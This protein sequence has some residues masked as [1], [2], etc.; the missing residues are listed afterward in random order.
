MGLSA[1]LPCMILIVSLVQRTRSPRAFN[2]FRKMDEKL[3]HDR[4]QSF[5]LI[6]PLFR[7]FALFCRLFAA[8]PAPTHVSDLFTHSPSRI[9]SFVVP[10][11][12]VKRSNCSAVSVFLFS[13][14]LISTS[15]VDIRLRMWCFY[16]R[17]VRFLRRSSRETS[18][19]D[20]SSS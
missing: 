2:T 18:S 11:G 8:I 4:K 3:H 5:V 14:P 12:D 16:S 17:K 15:I 6:Y 20:A 9:A 19:K 7:L 10:K 13:T 1:K